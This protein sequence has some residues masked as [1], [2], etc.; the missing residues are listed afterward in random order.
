MRLSMNSFTVID[1][2][3]GTDDWHRFRRKH[4]GAS[5]APIILGVSPWRTPYQLWQEKLGLAEG[6]SKISDKMQRGLDLEDE[7][8]KKFIEITGIEVK[9]YVIKS[10]KNS[11][12]CASFDGI[13]EDFTH[14][15]EIK[16]PGNVAHEMALQGKIPEYYIPQLNHQMYVCDLEYIFYFSYNEHSSKVLK[17]Y[18]N[19][20]E[21]QR[22]VD[23]ERDFWDC[24]QELREPKFTEKD[25]INKDQDS[26]WLD[27]AFEWKEAKKQMDYWDKEEKRLKELLVYKADN[28]NARGQG[29][30]LTRFVRKGNVDY[31]A[32]PLLKEVDLDQYRKEMITGWRISEEK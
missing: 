7:A 28:R 23:Y 6:Y 5:D 12:S 27:T 2:Q 19:E 25:Y 8:R 18:R 10:H 3:Q 20:E 21:I 4:I 11:Y 1:V 15:V 30:K 31:S 29:V 16:C 13:C 26:S 22:L 14:S 24:V 9:P 32:V 17:F